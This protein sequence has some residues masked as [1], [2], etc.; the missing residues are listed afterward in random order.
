MRHEEVPGMGILREELKH[1]LLN[2]GAV[3]VGFASLEGDDRLPYPALTAAVSFAV[4]LEPYD[5]S[6]WSYAKAYFDA[7][8]RMA[9]LAEHAKAC[10][11]RYGFKAEIMPKSA[12][13]AEHPDTEFPSQTAAVSA[14]LAERGEDGLLRVPEYGKCVRFGT[15]FTDATWKKN[16]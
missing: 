7:E 4:S 12:L 13:D 1:N 16:V 9:L 5:D 15:V 3:K 14:A 10:L 11:R 2:A 6:I 8:P